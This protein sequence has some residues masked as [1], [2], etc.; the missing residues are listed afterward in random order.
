M[1]R[2]LVVVAVLVATAVI[3]WLVV[4]IAGDDAWVH[5]PALAASYGAPIAAAGL[6]AAAR[7]ARSRRW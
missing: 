3:A 6:A 2:V 4:A 1:R 7:W 5:G